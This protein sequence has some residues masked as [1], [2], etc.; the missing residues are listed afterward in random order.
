MTC[1]VRMWILTLL[2][3]LAAVPAEAQTL[4]QRIDHLRARQQAEPDLDRML[5]RSVS[6]R[7]RNVLHPIVIENATAR[8]AF[9][10]WSHTTRISLVINWDAMLI[11]GVD[12][13]TPIT[14][15]LQYVPADRLLELLLRAAAPH[16]TETQFVYDVEPGY[17]H[18]LTKRQ[19]NRMPVTRV[20]DVADLVM[21]I[22][23]FDDAPSFDLRDAL[24]NTSSG[25]GGRSG[26][27]GLLS[28]DRD[29]TR[30]PTLTK[31]QRG[32]RLAQLVRDTI[33]PTIWREAGGEAA[34]I[35]Y[36]DG[37]LV[38]TAPKYVHRQIGIPV[39]TPGLP[40]IGGSLHVEAT[41][42]VDPADP[43]RPADPAD[44]ADPLEPA[45]PNEPD[46]ADP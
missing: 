12:P 36:F 27:S 42:P 21:D 9:E 22:P 19:A 46:T 32:Q 6:Q 34:S 30:R 33:E 7:L 14:L 43:T 16:D 10:W 37:R 29:R 4:Q 5:Q 20:Y 23:H 18:V 3:C 11:D 41:D 35:R 1:M 40:P 31:A 26:D 44:A 17:I 45:D 28:D 13:Q 2:T 15:D 39:R 25:G 24:S 8:E 38:V